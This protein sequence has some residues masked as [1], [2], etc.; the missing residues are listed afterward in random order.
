M[1]ALDADGAR[2]GSF[3]VDDAAKT[4][5]SE[6]NSKQYIKHSTT[7]TAQGTMDTHSWEFQWTA[8][9]ADIGPIT[10]YAAGNASNGNFNP[11]DDYIYTAQ[12]GS[13]PV[14]VGVSLEIV[15]NSALSTTDAVE[16]VSYT[17]KSYEHRQCDGYDN[18]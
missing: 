17:L 15:G 18:A 9:D 4:Q 7:G 16:G 1:T 6:T 13:T 11:V 12:E 5:V 14:V 2:A 10:F 8:P 3:E